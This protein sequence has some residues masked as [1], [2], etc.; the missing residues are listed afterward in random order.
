[1]ADILHQWLSY[2]GL[3][4][5]IM[6]GS[7]AGTPVFFWIAAENSRRMLCIA[8]KLIDQKKMDETQAISIAEKIMRSKA[9]RVHN[10][11]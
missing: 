9:I 7:D 3:S 10:L 1:M 6:F 11:D 2:H 5:K 4:G 8:L